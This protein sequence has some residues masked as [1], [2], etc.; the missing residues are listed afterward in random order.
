ML[1][2]G[3]SAEKP[4]F[5]HSSRVGNSVEGLHRDWRALGRSWPSAPVCADWLLVSG[6]PQPR[7]VGEDVCGPSPDPSVVC[8]VAQA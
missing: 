2:V 7:P 3:V 1:G 6:E 4:G 5:A 8:S